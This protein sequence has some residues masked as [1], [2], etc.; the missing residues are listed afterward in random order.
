MKIYA[1]SDHAGFALRGKM[2]E[3][4]RQAGHEVEDLGAPTP[5]PSDYPVW[6][7]KVGRAVRDSQGTVGILVCGS[8]LGV[9]MAANKIRG[10]R[11]VNAWTRET[12]RLARAH[13]HSNV[14]CVG[15]RLIPEQEIFPIIDTWL[16]T[17][18]EGGRH[19]RRVSMIAALEAE[20]S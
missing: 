16:G 19:E 18:F 17:A 1:G 20:E 14:L 2:I 11:A 15:T 8:G 6:A 13:N 4:L 3:H 12:A 7:A 9:C 5:E 10:V